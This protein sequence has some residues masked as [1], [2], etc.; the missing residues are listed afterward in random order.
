MFKSIFFIF[1]NDEYEH[2][3][4]TGAQSDDRWKPQVDP[5]QA[6]ARHCGL[7]AAINSC[8]SSVAGARQRPILCRQTLALVLTRSLCFQVLTW[9][10][11]LKVGQRDLE[12]DLNDQ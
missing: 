7:R 3:A 6:L 11:I 5:T 10:T 9:A 12:G 2:G 1:D 4:S 8:R